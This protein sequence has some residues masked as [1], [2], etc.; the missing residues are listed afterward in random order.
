MSAHVDGHILGVYVE[1][2]VELNVSIECD[3]RFVVDGLDQLIFVVDNF[4]LRPNTL[5]NCAQQGKCTDGF[6]FHVDLNTG[7]FIFNG[8]KD[9]YYF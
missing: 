5:C 8:R 9:T 2:T 1:A 6:Q 3:N 7:F 4:G